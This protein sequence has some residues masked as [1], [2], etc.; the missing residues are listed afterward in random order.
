MDTDGSGATAE[1]YDRI[2]A[3]WP[4]NHTETMPYETIGK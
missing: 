1:I 4:Q 3:T 2:A